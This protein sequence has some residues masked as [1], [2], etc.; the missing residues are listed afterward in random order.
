MY[1]EIILRLAVLHISHA[2]A[3]MQTLATKLMLLAK[4]QAVLMFRSVENKGV[5]IKFIGMLRARPPTLPGNTMHRTLKQGSRP[6]RPAA[7]AAP[8]LDAPGSS[9]NVMASARCVISDRD[10]AAASHSPGTASAWACHNRKP[11]QMILCSWRRGPA[12]QCSWPTHPPLDRRGRRR[13]PTASQDSGS[14][15]GGA[16]PCALTRLMHIKWHDTQA[17]LAAHKLKFPTAFS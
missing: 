13:A 12:R 17:A 11:L 14:G 2:S 5:Q 15:T 8:S 6:P 1:K 10:D 9:R 4:S 3:A 16:M 7:P